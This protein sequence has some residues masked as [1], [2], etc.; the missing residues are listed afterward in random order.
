[1]MLSRRAASAQSSITASPSSSGPRCAS[2]ALIARSVWT[3]TPPRSCDAMPAMPHIS[4][5][6]DR[7]ARRARHEHP[8]R[9]GEDR[10]IQPEGAVG[11]VLEVVR[12]L[13]RPRHLAREAQLR[14]AGQPGPD[15]EPLPIG[16]DLPGELLEERGPDRPR[17]DEAH[18]AAQDV[19]ELRQLVELGAPQRA[20][21]ARELVLRQPRQLLAEVPAEPLLGAG[22]EGAELVHRE[23][24]A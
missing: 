5:L 1:M 6:P 14:E 8:G 10:E 11:D 22:V 3:S 13:L 21:G 23:L 24:A 9:L 18:V 16:G 4:D 20:A 12:E 7:A 2:A 17:A 15:H 19:P